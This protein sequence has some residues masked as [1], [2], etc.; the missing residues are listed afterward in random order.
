MTVP[1]NNNFVADD[2]NQLTGLQGDGSTKTVTTGLLGTALAQ[3]DASISCYITGAHTVGA[4]F[5]LA[6]SGTVTRLR[7]T[8]TVSI[9][10]AAGYSAGTAPSG[11]F[12]AN[13]TDASN[14]DVRNNGTTYAATVAS[15]AGSATELGVFGK[16]SVASTNARLATYH[17]GPALNLATLEGLQDTLISEIAAI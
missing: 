3:N 5:L 16:G 13:R 2:L 12:G 14:I 17:V 1:T 10:S 8:T 11:L 6:D 9:N 7:Y 4:Q 15:A